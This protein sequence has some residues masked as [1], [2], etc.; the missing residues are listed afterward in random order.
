MNIQVLDCTLRDG[1]YVNNWEFSHGQI[2]K[3]TKSLNQSNVDII[4]LGYL[5]DKKGVN[6]N[7]TLF[8]S[9]ESIDVAIGELD[10][11][12]QLVIMID[13]FAVDVDK[14]PYKSKT[15]VDGIRLAFH[16]KDTNEAVLAAKKII[17]LG[18][19]LFFQPM[20]TKNYDNNEFTTLIKKANSLHVYAFYVVDSF[21]SM[22]LDEF[23]KYINLADINLDEGIKLGYH[24]HNNMQLAF[25]NAINLCTSSIDREV[26]LDSSIYG[27]GRGAGN[28][29]TELIIDYLN[30]TSKYK[31]EVMPLLEVIDEILAYYFKKNSWGFSPTQYLSA[32]LDCHPNYASYLVN[33]KTTHIVDIKQILD[34]IPLEK[35]NS[36]NK[37]IADNLYKEYLLTDKSK[38]KGQLNISSDKKILLVASGSSVNDSLALIKNKVASD[39][40]VVIALNHKPQ[41]NCDYYFFSNQQ[42][43][44]EFTDELPLEKQVITTNVSSEA[45]TG[46]VISLKDITYVEK[47]F[48]TNVT[49]LMI[50]YLILNHIKKVEIAGLDGHQIGKNNYAYDETSMVSNENLFEE[51]NEIVNDSLLKLKDAINIE[52]ITPSVYAD[53]FGK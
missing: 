29:N 32:S 21:G 37:Q 22:T 39:N 13:L 18:Y 15:R 45:L 42:R 31:Y 11:T 3:I 16:Q 9:L 47:S 7:S 35:R 33:K 2:C 19:K 5:N 4:E 12:A 44:D 20:V 1:G 14:L 48:V 28:L 27:M 40:Y 38:A 23:Q 6:L 50:N 51:L 24:S 41:F 10:L 34:K 46:A 30:T 8:D 43:F 53:I 17:A 49:I 25:S 26:I 36:F 52:L